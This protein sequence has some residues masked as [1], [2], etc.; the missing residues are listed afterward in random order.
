MDINQ[1]TEKKQVDYLDLCADQ[2][3][4]ITCQHSPVVRRVIEHYGDIS[5]ADFLKKLN[6]DAGASFQSRDDLIDI[7]YRYAAPL[8]GDSIALKAAKNFEANPVV[9]TANHQGVD[10]F[11]QSVQGSL[12]FALSKKNGNGSVSTAPVF[13]TGNISLNNVTYPRG[14][15]LYD[16]DGIELKAFPKKL[17]VFSDSR[18][19]TMVSASAPLTKEMVN[20]AKTRIDKM[21]GENTITSERANHLQTLFDEDYSSPD[22]MKL[23]SYSQQSVVLNHRI[24][25][26]LFT[27]SVQ[28]P[29]MVN[30]EFEEITRRLLVSDLLNSASLA[31]C[32]MFDPLLRERVIKALDDAKACW[33]FKLLK[34]RF[35]KK[36]LES[37]STESFNG[38]GTV[39]FWG[40]DATGR[41]IPLYLVTKGQNK[42]VFQGIDDRGA[43]WEMPCSPESIIEGLNARRLLPS[44]FTCFLVLSFARGVTCA[45]GYFQAEYLPVMQAGIV[46]ALHATGMYHDVAAYVEGVTTHTY[47]SGMQ[48]VMARLKKDALIPA[49]PIEIIAGGGLTED[50]IQQILRLTVREAHLASLFETIPDI[51]P[52]L[53]D[54]SGWKNR[55]AADCCRLL[56]N[57]IVIK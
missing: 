9:L 19:R 36:Q 40:I 26:K 41:R 48:V 42:T 39:F 35:Y 47:L 57:K 6:S 24:W 14:L 20:R 54:A 45:G 34:K 16:A 29:E 27:D 23:A 32:V 56:E 31:W 3:L 43:F 12:L 46:D 38:C 25:K 4:D 18:K 30:L 10:Y 52:W 1:G 7:I 17:P 33:S 53:S 2:Y 8:I 21:A 15:L 11:A 51:A 55:L 5:L 44:L 22:V 50:D 49:G 28:I 37:G 13:S